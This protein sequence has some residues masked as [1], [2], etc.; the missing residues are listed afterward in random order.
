VTDRKCSQCGFQYGEHLHKRCPFCLVETPTE[1]LDFQQACAAIGRGE[2]VEIEG[3]DFK[4]CFFG[5]KGFWRIGISQEW[6]NKVGIKSLNTFRIVPDPSKQ[7]ESKRSLTYEE[8]LECEKVKI[9]IGSE[10][11]MELKKFPLERWTYR[12]LLDFDLAERRGY[13]MERVD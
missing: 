2:C 7:E 10:E 5:P 13:F 11:I 1:G 12:D 4:G 6:D 9:F 8:A 3:N